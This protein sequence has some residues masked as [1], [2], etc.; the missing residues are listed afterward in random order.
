MEERTEIDIAGERALKAC[1][2]YWKLYTAGEAELGNHDTAVIWLRDDATG[3]FMI[4]TRGE[5]S[6]Q[7]EECIMDNIPPCMWCE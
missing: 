3:H 2:E 7:L 6:N 5:Y 4:F 1:Y